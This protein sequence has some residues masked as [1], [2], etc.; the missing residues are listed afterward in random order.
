[1]PEIK[2]STGAI[3]RSEEI[4]RAEFYPEN[5]L[6]SYGCHFGGKDMRE[7]PYLYVGT[8]HSAE[9]IR[10]FGAEVDALHLERAGIRV[11]RHP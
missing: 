8:T 9:R 6:D 7:C 2:L 3:I 1:M 4:E 5:S 11:I 10:G